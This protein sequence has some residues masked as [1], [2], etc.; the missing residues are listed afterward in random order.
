[1]VYLRINEEQWQS[2]FRCFRTNKLQMLCLM[3]ITISVSES[4]VIRN[5]ITGPCY[6]N[7]DHEMENERLGLNSLSLHSLSHR[8]NRDHQFWVQ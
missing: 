2:N 5:R 4:A 8:T 3:L 7:P 1:M 6:S